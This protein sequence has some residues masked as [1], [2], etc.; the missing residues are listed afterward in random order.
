MNLAAVKNLSQT[1]HDQLLFMTMLILLFILLVV[2]W[3]KDPSHQV[4]GES[5]VEWP[6]AKTEKS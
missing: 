6:P 1:P 4:S 5:R 3:I 2:L